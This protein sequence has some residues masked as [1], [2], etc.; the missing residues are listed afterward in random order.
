MVTVIKLGGSLI[1]DKKK[2]NTFRG[3]VMS[4]LAQ[5]ISAALHDTPSLRLIV[6]HGSGSFGHVAAEKHDTINGVRTEEQWVGFAEVAYV[7]AELNHRVSQ[8][9]FNANLPFFRLQPSASARCEDGELVHM[10]VEPIERAL[11]HGLIPLL[12]GDVALDT[13]R[14]GTIISTEQIITYLSQHIAVDHVLLLGDVDGVLDKQGNIIPE[15]TPETLTGIEG[16]LGGSVGAD[17]TGGMIGKVK[18]M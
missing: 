15:I 4:R 9:L 6:T 10:A 1:T 17:V 2:Q 14:G 11:E 16:S 12:Y 13:V 18:E 5:E 3:D 7:A 8:T